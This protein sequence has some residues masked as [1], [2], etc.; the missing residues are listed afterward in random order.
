VR[1]FSECLRQEVRHLPDVHVST[2]LP[3]AVDTPIFDRAANYAGRRVRPVPPVV[4]AQEMGRAIV[5]CAQSPKREV[6]YKRI[7]RVLELVHSLAPAT[8]AR[9][10]APAFEAGNY[11][12]SAVAPSAGA[13][14]EPS[15]GRHAIAG[16][17]KRDRRRELARAF[18]ATLHGAARGLRGG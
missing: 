5:R 11:A 7:G 8:Y 3:Q 6:T 4:D 1:A 16:G 17:W 2:V 14:L 10:L 13:V 18:V 15:A 9:L 12:E